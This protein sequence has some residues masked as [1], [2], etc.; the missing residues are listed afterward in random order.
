MS[1]C[2]GRYALFQTHGKNWMIHR[3][4]PPAEAGGS[5][6]RRTSSRCWRSSRPCRGRRGLGLR[7]QVGRRAGAGLHR[8][9]PHSAR[10]PQ[11][12]RHHR[13]VPRAARARPRARGARQVIST[14]RSWRFDEAGRPSFER[15]QRA[16]AP[17]LR[18][19]GPPARGGHAG[20]LHDLRPPLPRRPL[21]ARAALR[22]AAQAARRQLELEGR[23]GRRRAT[24]RG[25]GKAML[26]ASREQGLE[27]VVAKRLDSAY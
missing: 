3:M 25:D 9:R 8:R 10:E 24:T 12:P 21:D 16:H 6:C 17:G 27:G 20:R 5:R 14:A 23:T 22:R 26:E 18:Q 1:A 2:S 11:R 7:D 15:L 4:D 19:R 13:H